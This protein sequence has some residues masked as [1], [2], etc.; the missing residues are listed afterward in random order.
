VALLRKITCIEALC[1]YVCTYTQERDVYVW[2]NVGVYLRER[3]QVGGRESVPKN[4]REK[5]REPQYVFE[6]V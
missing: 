1:W 6:N 4:R 2:K 5:E 3:E